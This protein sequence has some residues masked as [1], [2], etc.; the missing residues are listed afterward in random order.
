MQSATPIGHIG[1][2]IGP[3]FGGQLGEMLFGA[4]PGSGIN[5]GRQLIRNR[6]MTWT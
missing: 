4:F 5:P 6:R 1:D 3:E 2:L